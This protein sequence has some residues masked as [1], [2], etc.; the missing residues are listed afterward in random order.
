MKWIATPETLD[1]IKE[2][3]KEF[4]KSEL[5]KKVKKVVEK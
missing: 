5:I 1:E 3:L 4:N 2:M